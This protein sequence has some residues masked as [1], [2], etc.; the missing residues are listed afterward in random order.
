MLSKSSGETAVTNDGAKIIS[1][2][3][4]KQ[5]AA[6]SFVELGKAQESAAGDGVTGS[7]LFGAELMHEAER[8]LIKGLH[9]LILAEGYR[10][11]LVGR[12]RG[13]GK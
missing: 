13:I 2:L 8:L 1:E 3:L 11:A 10:Q 4:I 12:W 5:P 6:K 9:P 7:I